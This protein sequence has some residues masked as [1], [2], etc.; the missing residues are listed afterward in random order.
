[1]LVHDP[2]GF[3]HRLWNAVTGGQP[4][5]PDG[6]RSAF[7]LTYDM[8][9]DSSWISRGLDEPP[10]AEGLTGGRAYLSS[11]PELPTSISRGKK[12]ALGSA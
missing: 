6:K 3:E 8:D 4:R 5:W 9:A 2:N 12:R 10:R 1:M 11:T 7:L